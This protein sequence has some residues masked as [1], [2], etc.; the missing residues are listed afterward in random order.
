MM[1]TSHGLRHQAETWEKAGRKWAMWVPG[2]S[3]PGSGT[4]TCKGPGVRVH[5]VCL[6]SSK[7]ASGPEIRAGQRPTPTPGCRTQE[8]PRDTHGLQVWLS[9]MR[10]ATGQKET[11][12]RTNLSSQRQSGSECCLQEVSHVEEILQR[13]LARI[14]D[15]AKY[16]RA[17][18]TNMVATACVRIPTF[19]YS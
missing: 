3:L 17:V 13:F 9:Q 5:L 12:V 4:S 10:G 15:P 16:S 7:E 6:K 18:L 8:G 11:N 1:G 19:N 2:G 14:L